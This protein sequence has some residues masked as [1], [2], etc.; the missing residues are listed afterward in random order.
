[1]GTNP[2]DLACRLDIAIAANVEMIANAIK[3]TEAVGDLQVVL[4]KGMILASGTTVD[5]D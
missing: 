4:G 1:M 3:A 2:L 5:Y